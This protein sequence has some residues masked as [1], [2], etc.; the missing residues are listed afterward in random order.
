MTEAPYR[1]LEIFAGGGMVRAGLG[2]GWHCQLACDN[3]EMKAV[4]YRK[5]WPGNELVVGDVRDLRADAIADCPSLAWLSPPCQDVSHAGNRGGLDGGR[6]GAVWPALDFVRRLGERG[7]APWLVVIENVV[8]MASSAG[9][10][11]L[12]AVVRMLADL[13]YRVGALVVDARLFVPQSR[14]RL[15]VIAVNEGVTV[16]SGMISDGPVRPW[17]PAALVKVAEK[18]GTWTWWTPSAPPPRRN[19]LA[20][21]LEDDAKG[22]WHATAKTKALLALMQQRDADRLKA[23]RKSGVA[24]GTLTRRMRPSGGGTEQRAELRIDGLASCLRT[25]G[26]GS[27]A[28]TLVVADRRG[29]RTRPLTPREAAR[30]MGLPDDY[31]LPRRREA[32]LKLVGDGVAVPV[33]RYLASHL[34]EPLLAAPMATAGKPVRPGI[35]GATRSTTLYLVPAELQRLKGVASDMKLS[36]HDLMLRGLDRVLAEV[37]QR[38]LERYKP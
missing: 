22:E 25:P 4:T 20:D 12:I 29:V 6:S 16:P 24:V 31:H 37:G 23:A 9:G 17:H 15:F 34:L 32:A 28:Q 36:L 19:E 8:G 13:K 18:C 14:P 26:G 10:D 11:D 3:D 27:S 21:V 33:V 2:P 5:N 7:V 38:P 1:F 30:L 35:K